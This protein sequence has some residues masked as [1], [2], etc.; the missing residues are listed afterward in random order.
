[1]SETALTAP[2]ELRLGG[3]FADAAAA[4]RVPEGASPELQQQK[5]EEISRGAVA[6][7]AGLLL[8]IGAQSPA[9]STLHTA[10]HSGTGHVNEAARAATAF[11]RRCVRAEVVRTFH[12]KLKEGSL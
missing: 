11:Q 9:R 12:L 1:M 7:A 8:G 10:T 3:Q 6:G 2:P 4:R 5:E